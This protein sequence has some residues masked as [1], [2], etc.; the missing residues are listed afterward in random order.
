M[1]VGL[2]FSMVVLAALAACHEATPPA[3]SFDA[4]S[5]ASPP[6]PV[7]T[8][9]GSAAIDAAL[10]AEWAK[11]SV[12]PT[13]RIDDARFIRRAFLDIV[14]TIPPPEAVAAFVADVTPD[15]R[16]RIVDQL[17]ASPAYA[18]YWATVWEDTLVG[19]QTK[20]Q[21]VDRGALRAWLEAQFAANAPWD[22]VVR[23]LLTAE[24]RNSLG[25]KPE[26]V[27]PEPVMAV[28]SASSPAPM[29]SA[30]SPS[31]SDDDAP[32]S[33]GTPV[34]GAV[35]WIIKYRES[36]ADL[37]GNASR[38]F[39]GVQIQCAQC[40]DHKT[41]KWK[42]DDFRR[43]ASCFARTRSEVIDKGKTMG[44]KR[45]DVVDIGRPLPRYAKQPEL[46]PI[47]Q[48]EPTALDG[49]DM[50][51]SPNARKALAAW[52]TAKENP[53][54]AKAIVNRTWGHFLGRGFVDPVDDLR[55]SNPPV[56]PQLFDQVS[57][58]FVAHGFDLKALIRTITST[59]A[60]QLAPIA[61]GPS[62]GPASADTWAHFHMTPLGPN[63][64][65][66]SLLDATGVEAVF[67]KNAKAN[68]DRIR[69]QLYQRYSF[70]FDVD[71]SSDQIDFEGTIAQA[72]TLLNGS[73]VGGGV[74]AIPGGALDAIL[75]QPGSDA[76]R[77]AALY[78]RTIA[79]APLPDELAYWTRYVTDPHPI[80]PSAAPPPPR[81]LPPAA[82]PAG[83]GKKKNGKPGKGLP[84]GPD[85]F[86]RL[87]MREENMRPDPRRQAYEDVFWAL[88]NSS[89][90]T[91]NH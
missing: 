73:E 44:R 27:A 59:E 54:F 33:D 90:F 62:A 89:E 19:W 21:V 80:D 69:L 38:L 29:A 61:A 13:P 22:Q 58:D 15:K 3:T 10:R 14:G 8:P 17:L 68:L 76:D 42:Q 35:N 32:P 9:F 41:E 67:A 88:L 2:L 18:A 28:P 79:R 87:E 82:G 52:V 77:I 20:D 57:A 50:G 26:G 85:A 60:Y 75:K 4:S 46:S 23:G 53:W 78:R 64:L 12:T 86:K 40:H 36:P 16:A 6:A 24:G 48:A 1:R 70:L 49:T 45:V 91:F 56:M 71:E 30:P 84:P 66:R 37:A 43:F 81:P 51:T 5:T 63:E 39:L 74:S 11:A 72:L 55:P 47:S 83:K 7:A 31:A 65:L 25:G 34:N